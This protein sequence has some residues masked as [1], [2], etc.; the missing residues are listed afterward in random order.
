MRESP[1]MPR[2]PGRVQCKGPVRVTVEF[3]DG[4]AVRMA[5][6][7]T[8]FGR[9]VRDAVLDLEDMGPPSG[10]GNAPGGCVVPFRRAA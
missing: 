7:N 2:L 6:S 10:G 5:V 4:R 3:V 9:L 1:S 8:R